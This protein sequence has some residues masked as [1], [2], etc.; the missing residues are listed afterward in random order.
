MSFIVD[1]NKK[2]RIESWCSASDKKKIE[3]RNALFLLAFSYLF[4]GSLGI[5][6]M[7]LLCIQIGSKSIMLSDCTLVILHIFPI[8]TSVFFAHSV[9]CG[10]HRWWHR[11][12]PL[13]ESA[14]DIHSNQW[15]SNAKIVDMINVLVPIWNIHSIWH[16]ALWLTKH[17]NNFFPVTLF[18][19]TTLSLSFSLFFTH[20]H[21][22]TDN[23]TILC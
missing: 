2:R 5:I 15:K 20:S 17:F 3:T 8:F 12:Y 23:H 9:Y 14:R 16:Y 6:A 7:H 13:K 4:M 11:G 1:R 21:S 19:P 22:I 10:L 18:L